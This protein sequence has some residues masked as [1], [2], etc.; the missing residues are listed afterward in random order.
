MIT[1]H[2]NIFS[3]WYPY[4]Q[5]MKGSRLDHVER[6]DYSQCTGT[7]TDGVRIAADLVEG[8]A[9]V[10]GEPRLC[11]GFR[12]RFATCRNGQLTYIAEDEAKAMA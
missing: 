4:V 3:E 8:C 1:I 9:Y 11:G 2:M 10:I 5:R 12:V 7:S 6:R